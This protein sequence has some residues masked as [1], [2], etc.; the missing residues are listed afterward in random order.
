MKRF[1]ST[2]GK[3][4]V[5]HW[6]WTAAGI[7]ALY[8]V[9]TS[10][11]ISL[12]PIWFDEGYSFA[13]ARFDYGMIFQLTA[14]D[15]HPPMYYWAL[16]TWMELFGYSE[17]AGRS[18][19]LVFGVVGLIGL[20][21]LL[22]RLLSKKSSVLM[23][24]FFV[25]IAPQ[26]IRY[27]EEMRMYTMATAIVVWATYALVR[28]TYDKKRTTRWWVLYGILVS[29]GMWTHYFTAVAWL[30]HWTWRAMERRSGRLAAFWTREWVGTFA[31]AIV[32]YVPWLP[33]LIKQFRGIQG[34]FW[35]PPVSA[36]TPVDY[37]SNTFMYV[38]N[39]LVTGWIAVVFY[40]LVVVLAVLFGSV[41]YRRSRLG[42]PE[43]TVIG[44]FAAMAVWPVLYLILLSLPPLKSTFVDR[45][46]LYSGVF[47]VALVPLVAFA[48]A[49]HW[50]RIWMT[51]GFVMIVQLCG[52]GSVYV[53]HGLYNSNS[54]NVVGTRD[55][56]YQINKNDTGTTPIVISD[57]WRYY[58]ALPYS[59][60]QHK[61]MLLDDGNYPWGSYDPIKYQADRS[62]ILPV[63][64]LAISGMSTVWVIEAAD[65]ANP[66]THF[67]GW[68]ITKTFE[69]TDAWRGKVD[70][71]AYRLERNS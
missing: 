55:L 6:R 56:I 20:T 4:L 35:I 22:N 60:S 46:V 17:L 12:W 7:I 23:I 38:Q 39:Q 8:G 2:I 5:N 47:L 9:I 68:T 31:L 48:S 64:Q 1:F 24:L 67:D 62:T 63:Q 66:T 43:R 21:M 71:K 16:H 45:Y 49:W 41:W 61:V 69:T 34:G 40:V 36:Y 58:E 26:F 30:G 15:V 25:A 29:L 59:T 52:V 44:L 54:G 65:Q 14:N 57:K 18:L 19:S 28:A 27:G 33:V 13:L 50:R 32:L 10:F 70:Y 11:G 51:L 3:K 53:L 37:L 42:T